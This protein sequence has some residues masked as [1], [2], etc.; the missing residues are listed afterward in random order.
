MVDNQLVAIKNSEAP[1]LSAA[2]CYQLRDLPPEADWFANID[3]PNTRRA[4]QSDLKEFI[5]FLNHD[6]IENFREV[7]RLHVIA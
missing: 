7:T 4:Y 1:S 5:D 6:G 3:N 2:E